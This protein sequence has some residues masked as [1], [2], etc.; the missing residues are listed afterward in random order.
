M[1]TQ[2][3][4]I[5][6]AGPRVL[7]PYVGSADS[8]TRR[9]WGAFIGP[10]T[11][12]FCLFYG[13]AF[14]LLGA[15]MP[16]VFALPIAGLGLI[17]VW[18]LPQARQAPVA[19]LI[20]LFDIFIVALVIWPNYL[21]LT[22]PGLPWITMIRLTGFPLAGVLLVCL[23]VSG[24][25]RAELGKALK[26]SPWIWKLLAA[27]VLIQSMSIAFSSRPF[28]SIDKLV[29]AQ[30]SWTAVFFASAYIFL[31]PGKAER[32]AV[33][34]WLMALA[35]CSIGL[36]EWRLGHVPWVG[37]IPS[38]LQIN[39]D[40]VAKI[41]AG[42]RRSATGIYRV[43]STSST[44]VGLAEYLSMALPFVLHFAV[45]P[46]R[47]TIK[48]A[49]ALSTPFILFI[50]YVTGS[51]LGAIGCLLTFMLYALAWAMLRWKRDK[52]SIFGPAVVL[53]YPVLFVVAVA[54]TY[55][56]GR[57]HAIVW[58]N[59]PQQFSDDSRKA[60]WSMGIPKVI[61]HPWGYG[62]GMDAST[63]GYFDTSGNLTIDSYYISVLLEYGI[64]GFIVFYG[65]LAVSIYYS[66]KAA[67]DTRRPSREVM[68]LVPAAIAI[69]N[70]VVSKAVLSQKENHPL[71]FM[72]LGMVAALVW[73]SRQDPATDALAR[74][75]A[76]IQ[77]GGPRRSR[78]PAQKP[79]SP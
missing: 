16:I 68:I 8:R 39:D 43:Q 3:E 2:S 66:G 50:V 54:A 59:G 72:M 23:S 9:R 61:S 30:A 55:F 64:V 57:L 22:L 14:G 53:S 29:I 6:A 71:V 41:L 58:G 52:T 27:F 79:A 60:Q 65:M 31:K 63:L 73:R 35:V 46:Y 77:S 69:A 47:W 38:F 21:A 75:Q 15:A 28:F 18:A 44:S 67:L 24:H 26:A 32:M 4:P 5:Q 56:I 40:V 45:G 36:V 34:L 13:L 12:V 7:E 19:V 42:Q 33:T 10:M 49:S 51:R 20:G 1:T 78:S 70:F 17:T 11:V 25:F 74:P 48:I 37:H 62:M 76:S